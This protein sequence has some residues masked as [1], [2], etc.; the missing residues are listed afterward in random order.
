MLKI[1]PSIS[2]KLK[3]NLTAAHQADR[4]LQHAQPQRR[5]HRRRHS[6]RDRQAGAR[7]G[8]RVLVDEVYREMLWESAPRSAFHLDPEIF[9]S[10]NS[11]TKAYGLSGVRCGWILAA[12]E[13]AE[14]IWHINDLHGATPA[15]PAE[16]ISVAAFAELA[17]IADEQRMLLDGNRALLKS[18]LDSRSELECFWPAQG[19]VV[20]PRLKCRQRRCALRLFRDGIR[21]NLRSRQL[22]RDARP[23]AP[24]RRPAGRSRSRPRSSSLA[25]RSTASRSAQ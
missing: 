23:Y 22:L 2:P 1:S 25:A 5:V 3:R 19:T 4:A 21:R 11:L 20:F 15:Y 14:R 6:A 18:F 12:P 16:L 10:T 8:A 13:L 7:N 17:Q 9:L 24:R